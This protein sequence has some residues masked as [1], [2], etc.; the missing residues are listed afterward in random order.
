MGIKKWWIID[1]VF[2]ASE[3]F[4]LASISI[5]GTGERKQVVPEILALCMQNK[6]LT[7]DGNEAFHCS[8]LLS[9]LEAYFSKRQIPVFHVWQFLVS[10]IYRSRWSF[11]AVCT[12]FLATY[13]LGSHEYWITFRRLSILLPLHFCLMIHLTSF[14]LSFCSLA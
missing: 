4:S 9:S 1:S 5:A 12:S 14:D 6:K 2:V 10:S 13:K 8:T 11:L 3:V 7:S